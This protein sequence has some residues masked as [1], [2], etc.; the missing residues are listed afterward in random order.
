MCHT[1]LEEGRMAG[2]HRRA[3]VEVTGDDTYERIWDLVR[4][5]AVVSVEFV[6]SDDRQML[7]TTTIVDDHGITVDQTLV[8]V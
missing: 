6:L 5:G 8:K 2:K 1:H 4:L 3:V 7:A